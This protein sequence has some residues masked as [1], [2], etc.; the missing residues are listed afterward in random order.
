MKLGIVIGSVREGRVSTNLAAWVAAEAKKRDGVE[1]ELIDLK[2]YQLPFF[3]EAISPQYNPDRKP[4]GEV[5]RWLDKLAEQDAYIFVTPEYNRSIPGALKNAIDFVAY[6]MAKKPVAIAT[7]GSTE[8]AQAV[9]AMRMI[10]PAVL[11]VTTP[12]FVGISYM[13]AQSIT[14]QGEFGGDEA[15]MRTG[16]LQ[17]VLEEL[18]WYGDT[19]RPSHQ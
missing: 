12:T 10:I 8:G 5:K 19:L 13:G 3:A 18:A 6:E 1:V 7:H 2:D 9:A 17:K 4:E 14:D 15:E 16:L 11:A